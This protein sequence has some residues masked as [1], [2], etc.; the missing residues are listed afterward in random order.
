[1]KNPL[2]WLS[3]V[4]GFAIVAFGI[5]AYAGL[6]GAKS[7]RRVPPT[8]NVGNIK[9]QP[10]VPAG[11]NNQISPVTEK[12]TAPAK[13]VS[14]RCQVSFPLFPGM[15]KTSEDEFGAILTY[16]GQ[17]RITLTCQKEI[18]RPPVP[19]EKQQ[20]VVV[21]GQK[22]M[23]YDDASQ[24]DGTSEPKLIITHP[25]THEDIYLQASIPTLKKIAE[26]MK[27]E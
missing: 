27:F 10:T 19:E 21:D 15:T 9:P 16:N 11:G 22:G 7:D 1:M 4:A 12:S 8:E 3:A 18:P 20:D 13:F 26:A 6:Y 25:K 5:G 17:E 14:S 2:V 23:I 24:K